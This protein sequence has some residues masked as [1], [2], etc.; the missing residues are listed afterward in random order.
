MFLINKFLDIDAGG[1]PHF[2]LRWVS[3]FLLVVWFSFFNLE[4]FQEK[5]K[6]LIVQKKASIRPLKNDA[7]GDEKQGSFLVSHYVH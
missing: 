2:F 1:R 4:N 6:N 5:E 7:C 3:H